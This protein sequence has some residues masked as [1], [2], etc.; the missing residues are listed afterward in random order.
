MHES[1]EMTPERWR[2]T[3]AYL[4]E[5][6]GKQDAHLSTLMEEGVAR[7]LP[8]IAV[9]PDVGRLICLLTSMTAGRVAIE[10]GTLGGYST[11]WL[12]RGMG[13]AG[14][15]ITIEPNARHADFALDQFVRAGV[16]SAVELRRG[17]GLQVLASLAEELPPKSVDVVFL[18][19]LKSEYPAYFELVRP[20]VAPG[21]LLLADNI[22]GAGDWWIDDEDRP[23]RNGADELSR[24]LAADPDFEAAAVPLREGLLIARRTR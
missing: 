22:L 24:T 21:G 23:S 15:V 5:T 1:I 7:G 3:N 16:A 13:P 11:I 10:V 14:R 8:D 4:R 6:F 9:S 18:D 12:A 20:L 19:A 17:T 2:Y